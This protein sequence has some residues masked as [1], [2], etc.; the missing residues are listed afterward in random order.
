MKKQ[1]IE[2]DK[3]NEMLEE[4]SDMKNEG[5]T[6]RDFIE[7]SKC[8]FEDEPALFDWCLVDEKHIEEVRDIE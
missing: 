7:V 3:L 6:F 4:Y 5:E 8:I 1:M 2:L